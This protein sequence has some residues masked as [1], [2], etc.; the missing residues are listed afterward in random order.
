MNLGKV[1]VIIQHWRLEQICLTHL[2]APSESGEEQ[3]DVLEAEEL[4]EGWPLVDLL[5]VNGARVDG[6]DQVAEEH[7]VAEGVG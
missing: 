2:E 4:G 3:S 7:P 6:V 1:W 5:H